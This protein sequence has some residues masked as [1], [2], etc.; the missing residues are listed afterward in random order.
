MGRKNPTACVYMLICNVNGKIYIGETS[1]YEDRMSY[2]KSTRT[3]FK[4]GQIKRTRPIEAAIIEYGF[5][6]FTSK[7]LNKSE[8]MV[9]VKKRLEYE[10]K[11]IKKL[12]ATDPSEGY[13]LETSTLH[14]SPKNYHGYKHTTFTKMAKSNPIISYNIS[15]GEIFMWMGSKSFADHLG[16]DKSQ[17]ARSLKNGKAIHGYYVFP[18]NKDKREKYSEN[19]INM[20]KMATRLSNSNGSS[21]TT[22]ELYKEA[23]KAVR[24]F[25]KKIGLE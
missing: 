16:C 15:D 2:Y 5:D 19:I 10:K 25:C 3:R 18:T 11:M 8:D 7:I 4:R 20:K 6:S 9:D 17:V 24:K 13:N 12:N 14:R 21:K 23:Y 1:N 22:L